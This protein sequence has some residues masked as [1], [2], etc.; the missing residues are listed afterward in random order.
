MK[1]TKDEEEEN[2]DK[3]WKDETTSKLDKNEKDTRYL[4]GKIDEILDK[5]S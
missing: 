4:K 2:D 1:Y 3:K 5:L